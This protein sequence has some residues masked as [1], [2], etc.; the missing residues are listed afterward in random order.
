MKV[1]AIYFSP[2]GATERVALAIAGAM[3][4]EVVSMNLCDR[5]TDASALDL[6]TEDV[7][8]LAAPAFGGRI[9]VASVERFRKLAG[10]GG[11]AVLVATY[12]NR[13]YE[14]TMVELADIA[15]ACGLTVVAGI[16]AVTEHSIAREFGAGRPNAEDLAQLQGFGKQIMVKIAENPEKAV[17]IPGNRPYK[18]FGGVSMVPKGN[19]NCVSCGACATKC[20]VAAIPVEAP[21]TTNG[22]LCIA[23]MRCVSVCPVH[24]R[25]LNKVI[26][27]GVHQRLKKACSIPKE[28]EL[29]I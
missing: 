21:G 3:A 23:C 15:E 19:K 1:Y 11:K 8:I 13:E 10:N 22:D 16:S 9:P 14:D 7:C 2:T 28:N 25:D 17:D 29:F 6:S 27:L 20:P 4:A 12:G 26:L 18:D 24:A 5:D